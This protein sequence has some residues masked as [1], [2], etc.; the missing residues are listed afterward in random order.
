MLFRKPLFYSPNG[1]SCESPGQRPGERTEKYPA[2]KGRHGLRGMGIFTQVVPPLQG[3]NGNLLS[4]PGR[5]PGLS[6][7]APLGLW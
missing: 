3:G 5:G 2:L 6:H 1:A 4:H 7:L